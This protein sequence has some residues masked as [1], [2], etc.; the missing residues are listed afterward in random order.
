MALVLTDKWIWDFWFAQDGPDYHLFFLQADRALGDSEL[1]HWNVSIGHARSRDL[2]NWE[3]LGTA[4]AP[5]EASDAADNLTTWTGSVIRHDGL[6]YLFYTGTSKAE[7]GHIQRVCLATSEDLTQWERHGANPIVEA[8]RRFYEKLGDSSWRDEAWRDPFVFR[9]DDDGLFH[10]LVT[11]RART[12][13]DDSRG[14]V[15]HAVSRNL[16]DWQVL[17]PLSEPGRYAEM[18]VPQIIH[19]DER[20][21]LFFSTTAECYGIAHSRRVP[22][23]AVTGF[24]YMAGDTPL[25]PFRYTQE[26][27]FVGDMPGSLYSGKAVRGPEGQWYMMAFRNFD[28][29][30]RFLGELT[31]PMPLGVRQDGSLYMAQ[32]D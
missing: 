29:D 18:E 11:A 19:L 23:G 28:R 16:V 4:L 32:N 21:Y 24:H 22:G 31:D 30:N 17:P 15:G 20:Y 3:I 8:D 7:D 14:V 27:F 12:G 5:S 9:N 1:R 6:W 10:M 26:E 25:G 2:Y 13:P